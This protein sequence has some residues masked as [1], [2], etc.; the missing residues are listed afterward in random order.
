MEKRATLV[1]TNLLTCLQ[2]ERS[3]PSWP[4]DSRKAVFFPLNWDNNSTV[5]IHNENTLLVWIFFSFFLPI[6]TII[7]SADDLTHRAFAI[8]NSTLFKTDCQ[9]IPPEDIYMEIFI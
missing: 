8:A 4:K 5:S 6:H 1:C 9:L 2:N 3:C 7:I